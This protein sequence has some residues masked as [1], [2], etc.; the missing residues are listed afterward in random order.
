MLTS[1][2]NQLQLKS[3]NTVALAYQPTLKPVVLHRLLLL[4]RARE[5]E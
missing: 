5:D 4:G 3:E 1:S 2:D